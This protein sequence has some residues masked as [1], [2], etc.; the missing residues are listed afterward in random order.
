M[1]PPF[2]FHYNTLDKKGKLNAFCWYACLIIIYVIIS[3]VFLIKSYKNFGNTTFDYFLL[4]DNWR[5]P[6]ISSIVSANNGTCPSNYSSLFDYVWAGTSDGCDC[7]Y[8][9]T[10]KKMQK[11]W[12]DVETGACSKDQLISNCR[13]INNVVSRTMNKWADGVLW[14]VKRDDQETFLNRAANVQ[15]DGSC[16]SGYKKCGSGNGFN[17]D[18]VFCTASTQCPINSI[19][20][21]KTS[22]GTGYIESLP[23]RTEQGTGYSLYWSRNQSNAFPI[24]DLRINEEE[25]CLDNT[26]FYLSDEHN[27]YPLAIN[28]RTK[29]SELDSRFTALDWMSEYDFFYNNNFDE[30][31]RILPEYNLSDTVNWKLFYRPYIDFKVSCRYMLS[32]LVDSEDNATT[33]HSSIQTSVTIMGILLVIFGIGYLVL[34]GLAFSK[35]NEMQESKIAP[36]A[37]FLLN[38]ILRAVCIILSATTKS[39]INSFA[40]IFDFLEGTSCSDDVTNVFFNN[41]SKDLNSTVILD[42]N[43]IIF[44]N[45]ALVVIDVLLLVFSYFYLKGR[46]EAEPEPVQTNE[47]SNV[48][49]KQLESPERHSLRTDQPQQNFQPNNQG[50]GPPQGYGYG[51]PPQQGG[52]PGAFGV[53]GYSPNQGL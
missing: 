8:A 26:I 23:F 42:M 7:R 38:Y 53:G 32:N 41:L 2:I 11:S 4:L 29:C 16:K 25:M 44:S 35:T 52:Y 45:I 49:F 3:A 19:V 22:P 28:K 1:K 21:S 20:L 30:I 37:G 27:E 24:V 18:R 14:C 39:K 10:A 33:L 13:N 43:V 50:Y 9:T 51:Q 36:I 31:S 6:T 15:P 48:G 40:D 5:Q 47:L 34:V 12:D 46:T 17:N